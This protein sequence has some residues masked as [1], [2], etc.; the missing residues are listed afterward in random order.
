VE[1]ANPMAPP[2]R[3]GAAVSGSPPPVR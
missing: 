2:P 1:P 3:P